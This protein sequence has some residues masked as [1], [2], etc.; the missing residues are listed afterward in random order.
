MQQLVKNIKFFTANKLEL[1]IFHF[2]RKYQENCMAVY[3]ILLDTREEHMSDI[4]L[5]NRIP[6]VKPSIHVSAKLL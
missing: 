5:T 1:W 2:L 3:S 4:L 6:T